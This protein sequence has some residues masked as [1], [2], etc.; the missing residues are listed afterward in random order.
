MDLFD[1]INPTIFCSWF[2]LLSIQKR[3]DVLIRDLTEDE[4]KC[5]SV[6]TTDLKGENFGLIKG[7]LVCIDYA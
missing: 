4:I 5:Y 7:K 2:G 6:I 1:K 3:A